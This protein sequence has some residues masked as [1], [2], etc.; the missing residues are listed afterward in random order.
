MRSIRR[1]FF[2]FTF[3]LFFVQVEDDGDSSI[4]NDGDDDGDDED[5]DPE[6][7]QEQEEAGEEEEQKEE[8]GEDWCETLLGDIPYPLEGN[9]TVS[10][11]EKDRERT[12]SRKKRDTHAR[13]PGFVAAYM[14]FRFYYGWLSLFIH[15]LLLLL[16]AGCWLRTRT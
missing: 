2:S 1:F 5:D 3:L 6:P 13:D 16:A 10:E 12:S 14:S 9:L 15:S 4:E 11:K 7:A 8:Q